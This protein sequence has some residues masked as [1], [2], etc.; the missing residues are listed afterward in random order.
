MHENGL[1]W[2]STLEAA[3]LTGYG[4]AHIRF[5]A[6]RGRI[7]ARKVARDWLVHR[8]SLL[9]HKARMDALGT[10]K[11][12]PWRADLAQGRGRKRDERNEMK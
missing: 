8:E 12:S 6:R 10:A 11:H 2:I 1:D 4:V 3:R 7:P 9:A 5:L